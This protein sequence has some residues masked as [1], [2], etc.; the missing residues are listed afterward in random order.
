MPGAEH[1]AVAVEPAWVLGVKAQ[2]STP[3]GKGSLRHAHGQP[4]MA[5]FG[6][7]HSVNRQHA[8]GIDKS[9]L[10]GSIYRNRLVW[11]VL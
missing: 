4:G 1:K 6:L 2:K 9:L 10:G 3:Q 8:D 5:R 7:L 11:N